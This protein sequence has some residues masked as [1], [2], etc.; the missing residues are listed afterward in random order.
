MS[1]HHAEGLSFLL[2][3][4]NQTAN[5]ER[6]L[7]AWSVLLE[8][9]NRSYEILLI[10]DGSTDS[11]RQLLDGT[12]DK[13]GLLG[14]IPHLK[15][16]TYSQ[17]RGFGACIRDGL[18]AS[19]HPLIFYTGCDHAYNPGDLKTLLHRIAET[20]PET[21]R[22]IDVVNGYRSGTPISGWRKWRG[23]IWRLFPRIAMGLSVPPLPGWLGTKAHRYRLLIR[24]LFGVRI[25]DI[26]SKFKLFRK[27]LF[28]RIPIQSDGDF[29]HA[30]IL[31]KAN[32]LGCLMDELP[33]ALRPG[34]FPAHLESPSPVPLGK[35]LRRVFFHPDFGPA[36]IAPILASAPSA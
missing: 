25:G 3:V 8:K 10:D 14:R 32:F 34:P 31:A 11:T 12:S 28:D 6:V 5:I 16:I 18:A 23:K 36:V 35:E 13:V 7:A 33:I 15:L 26:D 1:E 4:H 29:V 2:P 24:A 17:R 21:G 30:E 22:K 9:L 27:R 19:Q 20:D